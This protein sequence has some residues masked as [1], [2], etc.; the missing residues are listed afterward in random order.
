M[1]RSYKLLKPGGVSALIVSDAYCHA[2]YARKSQEWFL[3]N[4][5]VNRLDFLGDIKVFEAAVH[6]VIPFLQRAD[7][8]SNIPERR[9]HTGTF[10]NVRP[11]PSAPQA[12]LTCRAFFPEDRAALV[13]G[14]A[15]IDLEAL[16]YIS[17]GMVVHADE[18]V[19]QGA[20]ELDDL[21]SDTKDA[22]HP[23]R[24]VEGKHL[25]RWL[26][27]TN[28]WLEWGTDRAPRLFR[29]PTFNAL[30]EV[31]EKLFIHRTAGERLRSCFDNRQTL[32]NHTVMVCLPWHALSGVRNNSLKKATRY[33]DEKPPR[34]DLPSRE[35]L[36]ETSQR[37]SLKYMLAVMNSSWAR[38]FLRS[39]RRSNTDLFPDD[40]KKLPVPDI[41]PAEQ[42]PL[43]VLVDRILAAKA[44]NPSA[45]V[46]ALESEIDRLVASLYNAAA[47]DISIVEGKA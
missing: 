39:H 5:R 9:H 11:L 28:K 44:A 38:D 31:P 18:K 6:N 41:T 15:T 32:C 21:V 10:G 4:A 26:P 16:C 23:C 8:A 35:A 30:Y 3:R 29:R 13:V 27:T 47:P 34:P 37:F 17:V 33:A 7:G 42:Q 14:C 25:A 22:K 40:W 20:F 45:D 43:V 1:E 12:E 2:K 19:A 36:E 24:F 46:S